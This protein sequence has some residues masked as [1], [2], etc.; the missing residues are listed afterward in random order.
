MALKDSKTATLT[1][2]GL[3][4]KITVTEVEQL[5]GRSLM[6]YLSAGNFGVSGVCG[7][8]A[9]CGTCHIEVIAGAHLL[10]RRTPEEIDMLELLPD[11]KPDS[12][13]SCQINLTDNIDG[14]VLKIMPS[15]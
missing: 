13:L 8:L 7:G 12:R 9:L 11:M 3:D 2:H 15:T 5:P 4:D 6:D 14:M 10:P 1:I